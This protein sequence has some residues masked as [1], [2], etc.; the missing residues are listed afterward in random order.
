VAQVGQV[1]AYR[2]FPEKDILA[3]RHTGAVWAGQR[4][5]ADAA[6]VGAQREAGE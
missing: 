4:A 3:V 1:L 6:A 2:G 5:E